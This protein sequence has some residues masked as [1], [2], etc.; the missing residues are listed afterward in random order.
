[1]VGYP[2]G[3]RGQT[4]NLLAYAFDGSNP[5]PTTISN[6]ADSFGFLPWLIGSPVPIPRRPK[7]SLKSVF[8][9]GT[10]PDDR[11]S[12]CRNADWLTEEHNS[13]ALEMLRPFHRLH[14]YDR[15]SVISSEAGQGLDHV[16]QYPEPPI[17]ATMAESFMHEIGR[18]ELGTRFPLI[19]CP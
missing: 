2:S 18:R 14:R 4:V 9:F 15:R 8:V 16:V 1:M 6:I 3:Q 11:L 13:A 12:E 5:S 19:F 17:V 10:Q 7:G